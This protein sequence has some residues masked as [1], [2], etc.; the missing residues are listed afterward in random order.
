MHICQLWLHN[1][2][3]TP[4]LVHRYGQC[5]EELQ[6]YTDTDF[7]T[8][9]VLESVIRVPDPSRKK[10]RLLSF[11]SFLLIATMVTQKKS[12]KNLFQTEPIPNFTF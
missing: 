3:L 9:E 11:T 8:G 2:T 12:A 5:S 4:R 1:D 10:Q 6:T 7:E